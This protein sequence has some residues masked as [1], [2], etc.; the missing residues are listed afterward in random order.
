MMKYLRIIEYSPLT[1][2]LPIKEDNEFEFKYHNNIIRTK[3]FN[4]KDLIKEKVRE[5][6]NPLYNDT[7]ISTET[8]CLDNSI[9]YD[10]ID[11]DDEQEIAY[12]FECPICMYT[13]ISSDKD[14]DFC[15]QCENT[16]FPLKLIALVNTEQMQNIAIDDKE[17]TLIIVK[18]GKVKILDKKEE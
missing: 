17:T 3:F 8:I 15:P 9:I 5:S 4:E 1:D 2:K 18:D 10:N 16:S 7:I 13:S 11:L 6:I 14:L 12:V